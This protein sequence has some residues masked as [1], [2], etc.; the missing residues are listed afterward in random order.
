MGLGGA[1]AGCFMGKFVASLV[2]HGGIAV[3]GGVVSLVA[4]PVVGGIVMASLETTLA[5]PIE[6]FTTTM[7][8]A[9]GIAGAV[10]TG[11]V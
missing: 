8:L 3:V 4:T 1:T 6:A 7:A 2:I 9:G 5:V 11:P 10:A